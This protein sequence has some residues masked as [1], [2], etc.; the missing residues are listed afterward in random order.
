[1][2]IV[3][4]LLMSSLSV[5]V[6]A[7]SISFKID[8]LVEDTKGAKFAYLSTLSQQIQIS[9]DKLFLM[10]PIVDGKFE[11]KGSF[12][13]EGKSIQWASIFF[14][15]RGNI[16][17]DELALK[18]K[19]LIWVTGRDP[20]LI[21]IVLEDLSLQ[22]K[23]REE[24]KMAI[25]TKNGIYTKQSY[26]LLDAVR[27]SGK[28]TKEL[29]SF[30]KTHP[31]SPISLKALLSVSFSSADERRDVE[32]VTTLFKGLTKEIQTS[33]EGIAMKKELNIK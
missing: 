18:F 3:F 24:T 25:V 4:V 11:F 33:K 29:A 19:N 2:K 23:S 30:I 8:G 12:D 21:K 10:V 9:S 5:L 26:D 17:K 15:E 1:M 28:D 14:D 13:L 32:S 31:N 27:R 20:H 7:Q 6:Q 22:V 16:T